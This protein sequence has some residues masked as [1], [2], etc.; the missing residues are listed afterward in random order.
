MR[1][2]KRRPSVNSAPPRRR[3]A[4]GKPEEC[5]DASAELKKAERRTAGVLTIPSRCGEDPLRLQPG[6]P[7]TGAG[8]Q[9]SL[10]HQRPDRNVPTMLRTWASS[11]EKPTFIPDRE[12]IF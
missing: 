5:Q 11:S 10:G 7:G 2:G 6:L 1:S 4:L 3:L 8:A 9:T 12:G